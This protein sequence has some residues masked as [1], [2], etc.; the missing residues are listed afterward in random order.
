MLGPCNKLPPVAA[1]YQYICPLPLPPTDTEAVGIPSP[2]CDELFTKRGDATLVT[3]TLTS[4]ELIEQGEH[5]AHV[6]SIT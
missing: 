6:V 5:V 4:F 2:H 3:V 1:S